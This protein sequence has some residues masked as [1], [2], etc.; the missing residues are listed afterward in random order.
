[1]RLATGTIKAALK[2]SKINKPRCPVY[3]NVEGSPYRNKE[4][5]VV[6]FGNMVWTPCN[7]EITTDAV[8]S[9]YAPQEYKDSLFGKQEEK[10]VTD[11]D[12]RQVNKTKVDFPVPSSVEV[13][14]GK[15]LGSMLKTNFSVAFKNYNHF[16]G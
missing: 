14:A 6:R 11:F 4:D 2:R 3:C 9:I 5:M 1:M 7:W 12:R 10:R 8:Y 15:T 16:E 13:G